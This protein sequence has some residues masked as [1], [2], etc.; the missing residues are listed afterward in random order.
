MLLWNAIITPV[1]AVGA[2]SYWQALG[3]LVLC[4]VLFGQGPWGGKPSLPPGARPSGP[5][6]LNLSEDERQKMRTEWKKHC[7]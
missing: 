3:L 2:I 1:M 7:A 4:R 6:F 5:H